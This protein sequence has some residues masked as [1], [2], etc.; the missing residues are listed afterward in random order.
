MKQTISSTLLMLALGTAIWWM[1]S[2]VVWL[3][4]D[5]DYK[6]MMKGEIWESW[7]RI[8]TVNDFLRSQW[9]H[10]LNVNGRFAAHALVQLFN[11]YLGQEWFAV[12]N[13][14]VY[15]LF[16]ILLAHAGGVKPMSNS[17]GMLSACCLSVLCFSTKMMPT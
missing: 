4:D 2:N 15:S 3:G 5:I 11:A 8:K 9:I 6:Y 17:G 12:C 10:Y 13:A 14:F 1:S 16:A 7:G